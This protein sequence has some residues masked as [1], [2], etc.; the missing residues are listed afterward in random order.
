[1]IAV[2]QASHIPKNIDFKR[3]IYKPKNA[4]RQDI[5]GRKPMTAMSLDKECHDIGAIPKKK[6]SI[7]LSSL[8]E[9]YKGVSRHVSM[10]DTES[11]SP[12]TPREKP[13]LRRTTAIDPQVCY[14]RVVTPPTYDDTH[15]QSSFTSISDNF[16]PAYESGGIV[17]PTTS[18]D[19][20]EKKEQF[21]SSHYPP[22]TPPPSPFHPK[23]HSS[24]AGSPWVKC[25]SHSSRNSTT[26]YVTPP[27]VSVSQGTATGNRSRTSSLEVITN[28][29]E[30][31]HS[32][33]DECAALTPK[34]TSKGK[35][36]NNTDQHFSG[37]EFP[38]LPLS[39]RD[40]FKAKQLHSYKPSYEDTS[41]FTGKHTS[42]DKFTPISS[43]HI[44][45]RSTPIPWEYQQ[46]QSFSRAAPLNSEPIRY[47]APTPQNFS[48]DFGIKS[49]QYVIEQ[50]QQYEKQVYAHNRLRFIPSPNDD[51]FIES[52]RK[53]SVDGDVSDSDVSMH[54]EDDDMSVHSDQNAHQIHDIFY[55]SDE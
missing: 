38:P 28:Y 5:Q 21:D 22:V 48:F 10:I 3:T 15:R 7:G 16:Y 49:E 24:K 54:S 4:M 53:L 45:G 9:Q 29:F 12:R 35:S 44:S 8:L 46:Q 39:A 31:G 50:Q 25:S 13:I 41:F 37:P 14:D 40:Y 6:S 11:V 1:M 55:L 27:S 52:F 47:D 20:Y 18:Q 30:S 33:Y 51:E 19:E 34:Q 26:G 43:G 42:C 32:S 23:K 2:N 36:K 17:T